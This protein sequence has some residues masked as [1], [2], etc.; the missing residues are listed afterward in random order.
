MTRLRLVYYFTAAHTKTTACGSSLTGNSLYLSIRIIIDKWHVLACVVM[1]TS[2]VVMGSSELVTILKFEVL[3]NH[4]VVIHIIFVGRFI[5]LIS[6]LAYL[7]NFDV[8]ELLARFYVSLLIFN[9]LPLID[10]SLSHRCMIP[11][12]LRLSTRKENRNL[13]FWNFCHFSIGRL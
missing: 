11:L 8:S 3:T 13:P 6:D 4:N 5:K 2:I 12:K 7:L 9:C 10:T 1:I